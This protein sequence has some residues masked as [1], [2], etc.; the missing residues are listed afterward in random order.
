MG[1]D[2]VAEELA[3]AG[4]APAKPA[5]TPAQAELKSRWIARFGVWPR[6]AET[7]LHLDAAYLGL[8]LE[9]NAYAD[10]QDKLTETDHTLIG[11]ALDA[12]FTGL[13]PGALRERI[14]R[15]IA[16]GIDPRAILQT[17]QM[18]AHLGVHACALGVPALMKIVDEG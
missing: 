16:L 11:I 5:L 13:N 12:C 7:L 2:I 9:L 14:R 17:L 6:Y 3:A 8:V 18:T 15:A 10:P 1:I 4:H